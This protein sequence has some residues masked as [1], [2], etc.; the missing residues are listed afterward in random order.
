MTWQTLPASPYRRRSGGAGRSP[1]IAAVAELT[2]LAQ[3][4]LLDGRLGFP[5]DSQAGGP[6]QL[7]FVPDRYGLVSPPHSCT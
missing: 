1:V 4:L 7:C 5:R 3:R 6:S 2:E